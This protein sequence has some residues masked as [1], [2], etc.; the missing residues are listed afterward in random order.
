MAVQCSEKVSGCEIQIRLMQFG[1][2]EGFGSLHFIS[3]ASLVVFLLHSA[4]PHMVLVFSQRVCFLAVLTRSH[5]YKKR[6][7][8][9][10]KKKITGMLL[11]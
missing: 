3:S 9:E 10:E 4:V 11:A 1:R 2:V 7:K 6:K 8:K 5:P